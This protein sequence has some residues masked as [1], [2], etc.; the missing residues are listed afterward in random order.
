MNV[1]G[2]KIIVTGGANG[3]GKKL[4]ERLVNTASVVGIMDS[5]GESIKAIS[6]KYQKTVYAIQ[7]DVSNHHEVEKYVNNFWKK[8]GSVDVLV[9]NAGMTI[10]SPLITI[11]GGVKKHDFETWKKVIEVNLFS[12]FYVGAVVAEKMVKHR[13]SGVIINVSSISAKGNAGQSAYS[14]AKAG[15]SALTKVWAKELS[16]FG[17]RVAGIAPGYTDTRITRGMSLSLQK[18]WKRKIPLQR[19]ALAEEIADGMMF[20]M[21]NDYFNGKILELDGGLVI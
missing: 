16:P 5:D 10:D 15:V 17:I 3:I 19:F 4:I 20:I 12:V 7:C 11:I 6:K 9:N 8:F 21:Q 13:V 18:A 14:A 2:K 1:S